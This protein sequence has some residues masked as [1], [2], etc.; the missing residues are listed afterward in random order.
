MTQPIT[1]AEKPDSVARDTDFEESIV[2]LYNF[3][4][5][6]DIERAKECIAIARHR[7]AS[8]QAAPSGELVKAV[9]GGRAR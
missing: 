1:G 7:I 5:P 2:S 4:T 3:E 9:R 6:S 8:S